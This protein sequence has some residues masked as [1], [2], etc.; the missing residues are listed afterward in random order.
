MFSMT[1][2]LIMLAGWLSIAEGGPVG[3]FG[4]EEFIAYYIGALLAR[5]LTGVWIIWEQDRDIRQG[6]LSFKL[7][8]P[9]NPIIHY[10]ALALGSKPIRVGMLIPVVIALPFLFPGVR[11]VTDPLQ[12]ML[13]V[14]AIVGA[15][16]IVFLIQYTTGLLGFWI[17]QSL[18]VHDAW[19]AVFSLL[20]GYLIP[21]E[22]FPPFMQDVLYVTPFRYLLSFPVEIFTRQLSNGQ[23]FQGL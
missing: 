3:R 11:F 23:I 19:F 2:P 9:M 13:F 14:L 10:V 20:S 16:A 22:L 12:F 7:L 21:L 1:L 6:R 5:N 8:K 18:S 17:T 15:W 4:R